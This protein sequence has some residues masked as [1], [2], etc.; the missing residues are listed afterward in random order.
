MNNGRI[1]ALPCICFSVPE[2]AKI[3]MG[4]SRA[5]GRACYDETGA[6]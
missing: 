6:D 2:R 3:P 4:V 1:M 5:L